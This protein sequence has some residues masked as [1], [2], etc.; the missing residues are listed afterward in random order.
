MQFEISLVY[1]VFQLS[2]VI[3]MNQTVAEN[4]LN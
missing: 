1:Q 2:Q 3:I 4:S